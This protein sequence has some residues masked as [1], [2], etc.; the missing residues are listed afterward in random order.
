MTCTR[1][2][3]AADGFRKMHS[4]VRTVAL[5]VSAACILG[6]CRIAF[7]LVT[8]AA[9]DSAIN[10]TPYVLQDAVVQA[11]PVLGQASER[12]K[13][14]ERQYVK[15]NVC[16]TDLSHRASAVIRARKRPQPACNQR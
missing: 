1:Q 7:M 3:Q 4:K 16:S 2:R 9:H 14:H 6:G 13:L 8:A 15:G 12:C 5:I 11:V 10:T